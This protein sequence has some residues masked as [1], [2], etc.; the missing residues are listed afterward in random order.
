MRVVPAG[1]RLS[2]R[3]VKKQTPGM[4]RGKAFFFTGRIITFLSMSWKGTRRGV[5][6]RCV[7]TSGI[8]GLMTYK[9]VAG[10]V[11]GV[12]YILGTYFFVLL[13]RTQQIMDFSFLFF[14]TQLTNWRRV[15]N[16]GEGGSKRQN[17]ALDNFLIPR[18]TKR[19]S[20]FWSHTRT[21]NKTT[22]FFL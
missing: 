8:W 17:T 20:A 11:D 19:R 13:L 9:P 14:R 22:Y 18:L 2:R 10:A 5:R 16:K 21:Q 7:R 12:G 6:E 4:M 15:T 1:S 3:K